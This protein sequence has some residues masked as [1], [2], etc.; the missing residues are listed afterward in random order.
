MEGDPVKTS[1]F[2]RL[3]ATLESRREVEIMYFGRAC[4]FL[5]MSSERM[6]VPERGFTLG[7]LLN[8]LRGRSENWAHELDE[9]N[10]VC[11]VNRRE[12]R[13][14]D[15]IEAGAEVGIYSRKSIFEP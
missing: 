10:V 3:F 4:E 5:L 11:T 14:S 6:V 7:Q 2:S 1:F 9:R 12:A 15:A 13:F 8:K